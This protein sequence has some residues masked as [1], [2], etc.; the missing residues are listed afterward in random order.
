MD[1]SNPIAVTG[2]DGLRGTILKA[3]QLQDRRNPHVLIRLDT[4]QEVHV[5][6]E[7]FVPLKDGSYYVP[8]SLTDLV[9]DLHDSQEREMVVPVMLEELDVQT[10]QV[11]TGAVRLTKTVHERE[12]LIDPPLWQE[13]VEITRLPVNRMVDGPL[14]VRYEGDTMIISI[15]EEVLIVE[16][17]FMLKEELHI[18]K[19]RVETH[20]PQRVTVR[21]EAVTVEHIKHPQ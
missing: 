6:K 18:A 16:K 4:G 10:R 7:S 17:R 9:G 20:A 13:E 14:P 11:E 3:S 1:Q 5:P 21:S 8:F 15:L 19:R 12:E 2:K